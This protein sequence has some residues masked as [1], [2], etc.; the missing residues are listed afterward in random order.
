MRN[1]SRFRILRAALI[2][3][4]VLANGLFV[5]AGSALAVS[6]PAARWALDDGSGTNADDAIGTADGTLSGGATWLT[7]NAAVGTGA[8]RFDGANDKVTVPGSAPLEPAELTLTAWVRGDPQN[9]PATGAAIIEKGAFDCQG[10]SYGL[11]VAATGIRLSFRSPN[12]IQLQF[13]ATEAVDKVTL[14]D[15]AWHLLAA[16]IHI[17]GFYHNSA[18]GTVMVDGY[19]ETYETVGDIL[20]PP[21][22]QTSAIV[23]AGSTSSELVIGGPAST[24]CSVASF[25]GDVDDVRVY[26]DPTLSSAT[27][28]PTVTT[29]VGGMWNPAQT[30]G[31]SGVSHVDVSPIPRWG[32]V[33][34]E[35]F[36]GGA[37]TAWGS[38]VQTNAVGHA[39]GGGVVPLTV[40]TYPLRATF[41]GGPPYLDSAQEGT[42][43][44]EKLSTTTQLGVAPDPFLPGEQVR[45]GAFIDSVEVGSTS[46][47]PQGS[48]KFWETTT[49]TPVL[50]ATVAVTQSGVTGDGAANLYVSDFPVGTHKVVAE[51]VGPDPY[52]SGSTSNEVSLVVNAET[53]TAW[54]QLDTAGAI[55]TH[56]SFKIGAGIQNGGQGYA[57]N[58]TFTFKRVGSS[59]PICVL[60]VA[61]GT[62]TQCTVP[63]QAVGTWQFVVEYSGNAVTASDTS[64]PLTVHVVADTVHATGVSVDNTTFY[65]VKDAYKDTVSIKGTRNES[66]GVTIKIYSP[67]GTL[68]KTVTVASGSGAYSYA[69]NGRKSDGSIY[70]AGKYKV[71][72]TLKDAAG[73]T[74]T[75]TL[76]TTISKKKLY[77]YSK[78]ITKLGKSM[79][80]KGTANGGTL[81]TSKSSGYAKLYAPTAGTSWA[82]AGWEL[83]LPSATVY[84][85][86]YVRVHGRHSGTTGFTAMGSQNFTTC[87]YVAGGAWDEA[88]FGAW[89]NIPTTSG[90]TLHYYKSASLSSVY[91]SG[92]K[93]RVSVS[94]YGGTAYIYKAQV[95]VSYGVL[96]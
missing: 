68:L 54:L 45:L 63:S 28:M 59:T 7:S 78:T 24:G 21:T 96:K 69:W 60:P 70:A 90:T 32:T 92:T 93:V 64:V 30:P 55:E 44:V 62:E 47:Y 42:V 88:C 31:A 22:Q 53:A 19:P 10:P 91:R 5:S 57:E 56:H 80:A 71:V 13:T 79:T 43:T 11:Y 52:R 38:P 1:G 66:I 77:T 67:G 34:W 81:T 20:E 87:P 39:V 75:S 74:L 51:Y 9:P 82:G 46:R 18:G 26:A 40:G 58:A 61:Y 35:I 16:R 50:L 49:G 84:K 94:S 25:E 33:T 83:T 15:G 36:V 29:T 3:T 48:V 8:V 73:T 85:S 41:S 89:K 12:G 4:S 14:W 76:Y 6:A 72:Q 23:Y 86:I 95:I 2:V 37:W 65:P 27:L 17:F